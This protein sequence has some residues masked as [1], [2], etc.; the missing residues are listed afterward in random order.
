MKAHD[1]IDKRKIYFKSHPIPGVYVNKYGS[2]VLDSDK[3]EKDL[4][5]KLSNKEWKELQN[6]VMH[7][8]DNIDKID[9]K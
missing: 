5:H 4:S 9:K 1:V 3:A 8:W 2:L 6:I 7:I